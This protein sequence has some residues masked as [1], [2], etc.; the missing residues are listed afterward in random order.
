MI[1]ISSCCFAP[2]T[3]LSTAAMI[4]RIVFCGTQTSALPCLIYQPVFTPLLISGIHRFTDPIGERDE[5]VAGFKLKG[6]LSIWKR[7]K[8]AHNWTSHV[9]ANHAAPFSKYQRRVVTRV[10]MMNDLPS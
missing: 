4:S 6:G 9:Q 5:Q 2:A 7:R 3:N 8:Q 10:F 1:V